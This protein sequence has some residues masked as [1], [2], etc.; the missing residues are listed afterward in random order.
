MYF[1]P[2]NNSKCLLVGEK[3]LLLY[4]FVSQLL[5]SQLYYI[6]TKGPSYYIY[7]LLIEN[8]TEKM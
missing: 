2:F 3:K 4:V 6:Q 5:H 7:T 8:Q 1:S